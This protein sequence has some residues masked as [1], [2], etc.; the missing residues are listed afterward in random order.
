M[1]L[2]IDV[3]SHYIRWSSHSINLT[4]AKNPDD[5]C[6]TVAFIYLVG[7]FNPSEKYEFVTWD[8]YSQLNGKS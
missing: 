7:G 1:L 4:P 2:I 3:L 8:D 6:K 5:R